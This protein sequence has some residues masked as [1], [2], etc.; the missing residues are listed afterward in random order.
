[1][2]KHRL[3]E[4][5]FFDEMV[6]VIKKI[7]LTVIQLVPGITKAIK[8]IVGNARKAASRTKSQFKHG[9][10]SARNCRQRGF[11]R[12]NIEADFLA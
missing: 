3:E 5:G 6:S 4:E 12:A 10:H 2:P 8:P 11:S 9:N 1:M 7:A